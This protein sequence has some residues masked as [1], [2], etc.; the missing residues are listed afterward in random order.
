MRNSILAAA[1]SLPLLVPSARASEPTPPPP[2]KPWKGFQIA[3]EDG[4]FKLK[5]GTHLQGDLAFSPS[6]SEIVA[7]LASSTLGRG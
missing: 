1:A 5:L 3:S 7:L 2:P 6:P 4:A